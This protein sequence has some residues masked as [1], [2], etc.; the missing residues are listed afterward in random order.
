[1]GEV[2]TGGSSDLPAHMAQYD[3]LC[4]KNA[5]FARLV[6]QGVRRFRKLDI[7]RNFVAELLENAVEK[8]E[9]GDKVDL[10]K[11]YPTP[12]LQMLLNRK[13]VLKYF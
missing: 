7:G 2:P 13:T 10:K 1:M 6:M 11:I 8:R 9:K 3:S 12:F 4:S 5:A